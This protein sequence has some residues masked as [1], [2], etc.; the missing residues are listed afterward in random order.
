[1]FYYTPK[2]HITVCLIPLNTTLDQTAPI[3]TQA[4]QWLWFSSRVW[5][6][7]APRFVATSRSGQPTDIVANLEPCRMGFAYSGYRDKQ[8]QCQDG[9]KYAVSIQKP[10]QL[11]YF[12][13]SSTVEYLPYVLY[14]LFHQLNP[15]NQ[16]LKEAD[17]A[18][19]LPSG[20]RVVLE[21]DG[22]DSSVSESSTNRTLFVPRLL[23][24][25]CIGAGDFP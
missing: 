2:S 13:I 16:L 22:G 25:F 6:C 19:H 4:T 8:C 18:A 3:W 23:V 5:Y 10:I 20:S 15:S 14:I 9:V 24:F 11:Q 1:M 21:G 7:T 12:L 17:I